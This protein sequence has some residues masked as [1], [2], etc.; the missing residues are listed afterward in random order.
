MAFAMPK[1]LALTLRLTPYQY[2]LLE[3]LSKKLQL[4]K[5]SVMRFALA[6]LAEVENINV[7]KLEDGGER[8]NRY[9]G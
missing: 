6:R 1:K 4:D 2:R 9:R 3:R 7:V 8:H 5:T